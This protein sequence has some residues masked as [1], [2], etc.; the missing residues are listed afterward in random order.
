[1]MD[2]V[3]LSLDCLLTIVLCALPILMALSLGTPKGRAQ[4]KN[5][6]KRDGPLAFGVMMIGWI[7][8]VVLCFDHLEVIMQS[9]AVALLIFLLLWFVTRTKALIHRD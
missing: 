6:L 4:I 2:S 8:G 3:N 7:I 9:G 1:M 5:L